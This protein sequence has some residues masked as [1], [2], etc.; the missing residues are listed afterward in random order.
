[1]K[2]VQTLA[3]ALALAAVWS[4]SW[5]AT[6]L[7]S[8]RS[9]QKQPPDP[10]SINLNSSR[11]NI[12][13]VI[14]ENTEVSSTQATAILRKLDQFKGAKVE[15]AKVRDIIKSC[16][17][18]TDMKVIRYLP[19]TKTRILPTY[20]LLKDPSKEPAAIAVSDPGAPSDKN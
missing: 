1:M 4:V 17:V 10:A 16:G 3:L 8:S 14:T 18:R 15:E 9:M 13:R 12:Y 2:K 5:A 20:I 7:N 11:S 19:K 6:S